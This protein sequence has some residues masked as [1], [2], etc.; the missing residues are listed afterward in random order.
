MSSSASRS[1]RKPGQLTASVTMGCTANSAAASHASRR[2]RTRR[3]QSRNTSDALAMCTSRF[4][5]RDADG[6]LP[7]TTPSMKNVAD[8]TGR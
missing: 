5:A 8:P 3:R 6:F 1:R 7:N 2:P 4:S